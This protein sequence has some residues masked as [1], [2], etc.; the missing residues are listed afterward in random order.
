MEFGSRLVTHFR[1]GL[2]IELEL[3]VE[4]SVGVSC[5]YSLKHLL[6]RL[7][8]HDSSVVTYVGT[9]VTEFY[10]RLVDDDDDDDDDDP[11]LP[12]CWSLSNK[13]TSIFPVVLKLSY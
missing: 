12:Y 9:F 11:L 8:V 1:R 10:V 6:V 7:P 2:V 3:P 5:R 13:R 4:T